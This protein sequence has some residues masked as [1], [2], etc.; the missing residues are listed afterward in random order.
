MEIRWGALLLTLLAGCSRAV[1]QK[2]AAAVEVTVAA[3]A[4]LKFAFDE[5]A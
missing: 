3:A 5:I 2:E 1:D 4:D